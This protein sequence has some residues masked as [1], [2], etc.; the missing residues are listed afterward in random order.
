MKKSKSLKKVILLAVLGLMPLVYGCGGGGDATKVSDENLVAHQCDNG[1]W[2][3]AD[4]SAV[5]YD[6]IAKAKDADEAEKIA[7][8]LTKIV[9]NCKYDRVDVNGFKDGYA[10][11][12]L[13]D[14]WGFVDKTGKEVVSLKYNEVKNFSEGLAA[15][16]LD[17]KWGFVDN[18]GKEVI[19]LQFDAVRN[20]F[21]DGKAL[22]YSDGGQFSIDK[23]GNKVE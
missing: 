1:K 20:G 16:R 21:S 3:F 11:V 9:I 8:K 4:V 12:E 10:R 18:T 22:I 13:N 5:T 17:D 7:N 2:G 14:K 15:V 19:K 6:A 23:N